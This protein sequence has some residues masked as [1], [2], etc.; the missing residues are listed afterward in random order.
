M[1]ERQ[2]GF[3]LTAKVVLPRRNW[4]SCSR[5]SL[6]KNHSVISWYVIWKDFNNMLQLLISALQAYNT[7]CALL[8][9]FALIKIECTYHWCKIIVPN[10]WCNVFIL[11]IEN[12]LCNEN[13]VNKK[14]E[15]I[16]CWLFHV[17]KSFESQFNAPW[18]LLG[19]QP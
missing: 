14:F 4:F 18:K 13:V 8:L 9:N 2:E 7:S 12:V 10:I 16:Q 5:Y 6:G 15:Y 3:V 1:N 17:Q 19:W 11:S